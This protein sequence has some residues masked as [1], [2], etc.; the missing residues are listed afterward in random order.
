MSSSEADIPNPIFPLSNLS[1][2]HKTRYEDKRPVVFLH[3]NSQNKTCGKALLRFFADKG[4]TTLAYDLPGHGDSGYN[5][6]HYCFTDL[7]DLNAQVLSHYKIG[8]PILCGHSLGGMIQ[9]GYVAKYQLQATSLV[10][11]GSL[12]ANP[13]HVGPRYLSAERAEILAAA[14]DDYMEHGFK[15]FKRQKS[16]DYFKNNKIDDEIINII[17]RRYSNPTVSKTNLQTLGS[18]DVRE[19]LVELNIPILTLHG[20]QE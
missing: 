14:L 2:E 11:C 20:E 13:S 19:Q 7:I 5:G 4:H 10:M 12:D 1:I 15:L 9:A 17:N 6:E 8:G 3:G 18:F 16:Y